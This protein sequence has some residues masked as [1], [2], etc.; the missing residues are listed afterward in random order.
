MNAWLQKIKRPPFRAMLVTTAVGLLLV[1][2]PP[3]G[4]L[5]YDVSYLA[6]PLF[7]PASQL[8]NA[9]VIYADEITTRV[10][11]DGRKVHWT[12]HARLLDRLTQDGARVV[13]YDFAFGVTNPEPKF[14]QALAEAMNRQRSVILIT[15]KIEREN[16]E[17]LAS[18][19]APLDEAARG[20]GHGE[21]FDPVIRRLPQDYLG[22][23][24][25]GWVAAI[26]YDSNRLRSV[27]PNQ[28]RWLNYY[29]LPPD[30]GL[31]V[32]HFEDVISN[33]VPTGTFAQKIVVV[34]GRSS[35][36][37]IGSL[38]EMFATPYERF[39]YKRVPGAA[40]HTTAVL[41]LVRGDWLRLVSRG[42]QYLLATLCGF[43]VAGLLY[44][45]SRRGNVALVLAAVLSG[46][47]IAA[48]SLWVQWHHHVWWGWLG[49]AVGQTTT[50]L[51]YVWF[52]RR[53]DP[54]VAFVSY[55]TEDDGAAAR[56]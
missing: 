49:G 20:A 36:S 11:G 15:P 53:T 4:W 45:V 33:A 51:A 31:R 35:A 25:A 28:E 16:I 38:K 10:L 7:G 56:D 6:R 26:Q 2:L 22:V 32:Y 41:N 40:I 13:L 29:G 5:S 23:N 19:V 9:A 43:G 30:L 34:G 3:L 42:G 14:S 48:I 46:L 47:L 1:S 12:N 55:R 37:D 44:A 8:T 52:H 50:A 21:L 39:N 27:D 54:Y 17:I 24:Y 18:P